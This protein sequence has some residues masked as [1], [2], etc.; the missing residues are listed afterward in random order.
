MKQAFL[1]GLAAAALG[2]ALGFTG[3]AKAQSGE[4]PVCS[5]STLWAVTEVSRPDAFG[6]LW[7][8]Y[9]CSPDGWWL[10]GA[11]YCSTDGGCSSN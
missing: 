8:M 4:L 9:Q 7:L 6:T 1:S 10:I 5:E 11:T 3:P 2:L